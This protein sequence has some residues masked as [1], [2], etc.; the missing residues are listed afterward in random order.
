MQQIKF[1]KL[2]ENA[3]T[4]CRANETDAGADLVAISVTETA[5][6]IQ[7]HTGISV[8]IPEGFVG[9]LFPRSSVSNK[10]LMLANSVGVIDAGYRGEICARFKRVGV[11]DTE[12]YAPG[13][14]VAQLVIVPVLLTEFVESIEDLTETD[15]GTGGFGSTGN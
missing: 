1:K 5:N 10:P 15:R 8:E 12:I 3:T 9:L 7:Y 14:K 6:Y 13:E 11:S 2:H 4:P